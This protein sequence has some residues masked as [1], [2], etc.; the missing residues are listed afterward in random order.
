VIGFILQDFILLQKLFCIFCLVVL[1]GYY[2][3]LKIACGSGVV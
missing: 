2:L 1:V 3:K